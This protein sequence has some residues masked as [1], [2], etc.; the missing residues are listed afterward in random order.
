MAERRRTG[1]G[2]ARAGRVAYHAGL[3]AEEVVARRY[4]G[5]GVAL[6]EA[7]WRGEAGEIDLVLRDGEGLILVEVKAAR[8]HR[9][10]AASLSPRQA[11][12]VLAAGAEYLGAQPLGQLTPVRFDLALVDRSGRVEIVENAL[13][14]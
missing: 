1:E 10:A 4:A 7:R 11:E 6:V 5:R 13:G 3:S 12:R 8:S 9:A 14:Q 2:K